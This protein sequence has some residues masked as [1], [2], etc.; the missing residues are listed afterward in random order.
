MTERSLEFPVEAPLSH[1]IGVEAQ[2]FELTG[3]QGMTIESNGEGIIDPTEIGIQKELE[4]G[5]ITSVVATVRTGET[6]FAILKLEGEEGSRFVLGGLSDSGDGKLILNKKWAPLDK[7]IPT[8]IGRRQDGEGSIDVASLS[9]ADEI[10]P[11][12][13]TGHLLI[14]FNESGDLEVKNLG[15][16][17]T[18]IKC[19]EAKPTEIENAENDQNIDKIN[20]NNAAVEEFL[21]LELFNDLR[22]AHDALVEGFGGQLLERSQ[23]AKTSISGIA[24]RIQ[25][26]ESLVSSYTPEE[27]TGDFSNSPK[28]LL[29]ELAEEVQLLENRVHAIGSTE[30][31]HAE[32]SRSIGDVTEGLNEALPVIQESAEPENDWLYMFANTGN[33][34]IGFLNNSRERARHVSDIVPN[35]SR[36]LMS[37]ID[38]IFRLINSG[39]T[40]YSV[41]TQIRH[42]MEAMMRILD[43]VRSELGEITHDS[44]AVQV[45]GHNF[46]KLVEEKKQG[47]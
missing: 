20:A 46:M 6:N 14:G 7:E 26:L 25:N 19:F 33:Q 2:Q 34:F 18:G 45:L 36:D 40:D 16:N 43:P 3:E 10:D 29:E 23:R 1:E 41:K 30:H 21:D 22:V 28:R 12:V 35:T 31:D 9:T 27:L 38:D 39:N 5:E 15:S 4:S 13:S 8:K 42:N 47:I 17:G 11:L 44:E 24:D 32:V 37:A